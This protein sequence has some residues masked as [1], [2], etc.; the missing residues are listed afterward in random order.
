[1]EEHRYRRRAGITKR[2]LGVEVM[3]YFEDNESIHVLNRTS[4]F[5]WDLLENPTSLDEIGEAVC[6][7]FEIP[8]D[9]DVHGDVRNVMEAFLNQGLVTKC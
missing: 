7:H 8:E 4:A 5:I 9:A 1:M 3:L 2:V 6:K